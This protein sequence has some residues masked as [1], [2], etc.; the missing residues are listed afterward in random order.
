MVHLSSNKNTSEDHLNN[1]IDAKSSQIVASNSAVAAVADDKIAFNHKK[2]IDDIKRFNFKSTTTTITTNN[3]N[4]KP[5]ENNRVEEEEKEE[6]VRK[7][8]NN[9]LQSS[10]NSK[11]TIHTSNKDLTASI[12]SLNRYTPPSISK[13]TTTTTTMS[14]VNAAT[15]AANGGGEYTLV[16]PNKIHLFVKGGQDGRAQ[17][18]CPFCQQVFLQL[19]IKA[20]HN[21]FNFDVITINLE[22]PPK[23]FKELSIKPPVLVHGRTASA[24]LALQPTAAAA[25]VAAEEEEEVKAVILSDVDEI[26]EYLDRLYPNNKLSIQNPEAKRVCLN[27]FSKFSFFIR[28]VAA[29]SSY[30]ESEL[31][32]IDAYLRENTN[33][34]SK[35]LSGPHM[36]ALDCSL[37]PKLQ[38]IRVAAE[39]VKKF[40]IPSRFRHLWL[41]MKS[42][43]ETDEFQKSCPPDREI[44]WHWSK[45]SLSH[46]ELLQIMQE[47]SHKTLTLP[48]DLDLS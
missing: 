43:Y 35:F 39:S 20:Q 14:A 36:T 48:D 3:A 42:A 37:L 24:N 33:E 9:F 1:R 15:V 12:L 11:T 19:L 31:E 18:A 27:V 7:K 4:L 22:N 16:D 17:G 40:R 32:K 25:A 47:Y 2:L 13:A 46:K 23:E 41:Y 30:L 8:L 34:T 5:K 45:T 28:D 44:I 38:H 6:E 10:N 26:A 21:Q 29:N